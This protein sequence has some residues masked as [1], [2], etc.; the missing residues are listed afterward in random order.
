MITKTT[1][2]FEGSIK[3]LHR[4][5]VAVFSETRRSDRLGDLAAKAF[6]SLGVEQGGYLATGAEPLDL[7]VQFW[8]GEAG[9]D[10]VTRQRAATVRN[11]SRRGEWIENH[12]GVCR[13]GA[14]GAPRSAT[15]RTAASALSRP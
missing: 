3:A 6:E 12:S 7:E 15:R 10:A 8:L 13:S 14:G 11:G 2:G 5:A 9:P 4:V 1:E